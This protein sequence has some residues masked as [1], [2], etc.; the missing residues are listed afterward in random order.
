MEKLDQNMRSWDDLIFENRNK[1]YGAYA[2]RQDYSSGLLKGVL[3]SIGVAIA[4]LLVA[5]YVGGSKIIEKVATIDNQISI[6]PPPNIQTEA[7]IPQPRTEPVRKTNP[8]LA[9]QVVTT[10][11]PVEPTPAP[12]ITSSGTEGTDDGT[13]GQIPEHLVVWLLE[14]TWVQFP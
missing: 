10:P 8:D 12:A 2:L 4:I 6:G 13:G 1:A 7:I 5:G 11:D 9:V 3:T 14:Q